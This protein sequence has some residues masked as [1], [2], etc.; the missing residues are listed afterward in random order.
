MLKCF[1]MT[2]FAPEFHDVS[3][4]VADAVKEAVAGEEITCVRL[5]ER[6][7]AGR[8]TDELLAEL[9]GATLCVA[10]VSGANP[11]VMW[12]VG[13][14]S[15]LQKPVI[16]ISQDAGPAPF[17]I[18]DMR[19]LRYDRSR[20]T[21]SLK[22]ELVEAVR[23]TLSHYEVPRANLTLRPQSP[24][25]TVYAV[26]GTSVI[27]PASARRR[28]ERLLSPYLSADATWYCGTVGTADEVAAEWLLDNGQRVMPVGYNAYDLSARML[29]ILQ[30]H[31]GHFIDATLEQL[32]RSPGAPSARDLLFAGRADLLFLIWDGR[33]AGVKRLLA[34]LREQGK[35]H[36]IGYTG[37]PEDWERRG[38]W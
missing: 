11:N 17:D 2:P 23:Q 9:R 10:D 20:L 5:D 31:G 22:G 3:D 29:G 16:V 12:E 26:T 19:T 37:S 27:R 24:K 6:R 32:P 1:L 21:A 8:V 34:W 30:E 15:A 14:A 38:S 7:H 25:G 13:Y 18:S 35:D 33:S 28:I 4:T 36:V